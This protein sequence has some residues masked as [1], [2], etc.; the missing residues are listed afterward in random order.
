M[1]DI[2]PAIER[3]QFNTARTLLLG[4]FHIGSAMSDVLVSSILNRILISHF[5]FLAWPVAL[6]LGLRYLLSPISLWAGAKSDSSTGKPHGRTRYIWSGRALIMAGLSMMGIS[7]SWFSRGKIF[8]GWL[9]VTAGFMLYGIGGL[10]SG[11]PFLSLVRDSA[12]PEKRGLAIAMVQTV[13][14][15]CF[16]IAA[17]V[18]GLLMENYEIGLFWRLVGLTTALGGL[19]WLLSI[20]GVERRIQ[21]ELIH[22]GAQRQPDLRSV[23]KRI[24]ILIKDRRM[25]RF[26]L[27]LSLA[28]ASAWLQ[29]AILEP[30]G[31]EVLSL[32]LGQT[33]RLNVL[34][35]TP[36][37]LML[38]ISMALWRNHPPERQTGAAGAGLC[39]MAIGMALLAI[40]AFTSISSLI[41]PSLIA[42]GAGFG[43]YTFAGLSLIATMTTDQES[44]LQLGL[45]TV[46]QLV[47]RGIGTGAGGAI[48]DVAMQFTSKPA[49]AY[50]IVFV[51]S[52]VGIGSSLLILSKV[53]NDLRKNNQSTIVPVTT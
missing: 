21:N 33:T 20:L 44:G 29:E 49:I 16:P 35:L 26:F 36:T 11:S 40:T 12:P 46:A 34:W 18:F 48:R 7:L 10:I 37:L 45:W 2:E 3:R 5:G 1:D 53:A 24:R 50:G 52:A 22:Y 25:V 14:L 27:F 31:A 30:F 13:L 23:R 15:A 42:F 17:L 47:F 8:P 32:S 9:M 19:F 43:V 38:V 28:A 39:I 51:I 6:L 4:T 41:W